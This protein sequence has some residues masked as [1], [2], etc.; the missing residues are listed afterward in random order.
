MQTFISQTKPPS[1][2]RCWLYT[3]T[4]LSL[5]CTSLL[6]AS[7]VA[8]KWLAI[9]FRAVV[10]PQPV[11]AQIEYARFMSLK[12]V[13]LFGARPSKPGCFSTSLF[14]CLFYILHFCYLGDCFVLPVLLGTKLKLSGRYS[15]FSSS[16]N[17]IPSIYDVLSSSWSC[18]ECFRFWAGKITW[19]QTCGLRTQ[20][21]VSQQHLV[22][23]TGFSGVT[24]DRIWVQG[25]TVMV[26]K[27]LENIFLP[28][29]KAWIVQHK[30]L[31]QCNKRLCVL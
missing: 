16:Q 22:V 4:L 8:L 25:W 2:W 29:T 27:Y 26:T 15:V 23:L 20:W 17:I 12:E 30:V 21:P 9:L 1:T 11:A 28:E 10:Q 7:W 14:L 19:N 31:S 18:V 5:F 13:L 6:W 3:N 24:K